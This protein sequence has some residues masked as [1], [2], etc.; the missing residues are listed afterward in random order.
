MDEYT[1]PPVIEHQKGQ[2][3]VFQLYFKTQG[4]LIDAIISKKID[5][6]EVASPPP[7]PSIPS[8]PKPI[9]S[10]P[11]PTGIRYKNFSIFIF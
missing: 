5:D 7:S 8:R 4:A 11:R 6:D 3:K 2:R 9:V 1:L 10:T